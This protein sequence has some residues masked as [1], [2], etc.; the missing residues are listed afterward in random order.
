MIPDPNDEVTCQLSVPPTWSEL[1][2]YCEEFVPD[3]VA[4]FGL[5][6]VLA[7]C[8]LAIAA[9]FDAWKQNLESS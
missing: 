7:G 5:I 6:L 1:T 4:V 3:W 2:C 8:M 9:E